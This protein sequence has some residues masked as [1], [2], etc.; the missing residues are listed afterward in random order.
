MQ[1]L[2]FPS[3]ATP[4]ALPTTIRLAIASSSAR[5]PE[6]DD[7][8]HE[9]KYDG[10]RIV[11]VLDGRGGLKLISRN[12]HDR[13]P[14]F[15]TPFRDLLSCGREIVLDGEIAV[16]DGRGVTHIGHLQDALDGRQPDRLAYFA[17]DLLYL[18]GHD[19]RRCPIEERKALLRRVLDRVRCP[20]LV[21]VDH[22]LGWGAELFEHVRAI[23]A[24]GIVSK[25]A[26]SLYSGKAT[27]DWRKTKCH[28]TGRFI[29]TGFQ[30]LGPG[31][32]EALHVAEERDGEVVGVGQV[33]FGFAGKGLWAI[34]H[35]LR[36]GSLDRAGVVPIEPGLVVRVKY[37]GRHKGGA[38]RDGVLVAIIDQPQRRQVAPAWSCDTDAVIAAMD[39]ADGI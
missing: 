25:R 35:E 31:R 33:R 17:F 39:A 19:L 27:R 26:G 20:R 28:A 4:S 5:P 37:F 23:G 36:A 1:N 15:R 16:P 22:V 2:T 29:V 32:I 30:E 11:A 21:F 9:V 34:L 18:D 24:E 3:G 6:G 13:T 38:I 10:H 14:L 8:L 7:W 12:G